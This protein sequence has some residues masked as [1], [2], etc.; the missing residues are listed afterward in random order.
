M[1]SNN[2]SGPPGTLPCKSISIY[3]LK[4]PRTG[5]IRYVGQTHHS[6]RKRLGQHLYDAKRRPCSP[7]TRKKIS[8]SKKGRKHSAEHREKIRLALIRYAQSAKVAS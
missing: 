4:D 7:E 2:V 6:R 5:S 8:A 3:V 1:T